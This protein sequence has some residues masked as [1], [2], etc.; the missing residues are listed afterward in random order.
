MISFS[1]FISLSNS[2]IQHFHF[3]SKISIFLSPL[4][5]HSDGNS[6]EPQ[7]E[8]E[9]NQTRSQQRT[10]AV[11][12]AG[13]ADMS[14]ITGPGDFY[15]EFVL[16]SKK[17]WFLAGPGIFSFVSKYSLGAFTQIFAGHIGTIELTAVSVENSLIAGF[18]YGILLGMG[19]ALETLCGQAVGAGKLN[20][21]GVYMQRSWV[22]LSITA[23][24]LCFLYVFAGPFLTLIGQDPE[25]SRAAGKFAIWMIPQLFAYAFNFPVAKFLQTQSKVIVIAAISGVAMALHPLLSWL[26]I[27][28]VE[29]GLVG[30]AVVLNASWW[31]IVVAQLAYVLSGRCGAAWKGFS[32]EAF[33]NLWSFFRLSLA[34][35][36]MLCLEMW[37]FMALLLFAGYLKNAKIYVGAFSICMNILGWTIMVSFGMNAATSVRISNE[38][39]AHHPRTALFSLVVAVITSIM[40]GLFLA[41]V[42]MV[43][44]NVYPSLFSNDPEVQNIVK[45]LTP[46]LSFCIIINNVQPVLS[47]VG[48]GWQAF[49]AYVNIGCYY[50]FGIPL[51][52][53]LGY[54]FHRGIKGIWQGMISGTV[55]QT[56][57]ILVMIYKTNWNR[58]AS[59]A[60]DRVQT[61]GGQKVGNDKENT[62][63][64]T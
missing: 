32:W 46:L 17:L 49:V 9:S 56:I 42:L 23:C 18:S 31:F 39:G 12:T 22:L 21:L 34:S 25:I 53:L 6:T 57:V 47:A 29:W 24:V 1:S 58:E 61:W 30:A 14:P 7:A 15:R 43:T 60:G 64:E 54:K 27:M 41:F 28:K 26:L 8:D 20:M 50:L 36:V 13:S 55:L 37:Y 5:E 51:G 35:A 52:L 4:M 3:F 19:S 62:E 59:R 11:F 10:A 63:E 45:E 38:L 2:L 48:A 33:G 16:E 40:I 44:R